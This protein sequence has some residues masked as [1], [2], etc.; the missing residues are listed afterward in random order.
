MSEYKVFKPTKE[1]LD[2]LNKKLIYRDGRELDKDIHKQKMY[3]MYLFH[4][5]LTTDR[6]EF[7]KFYNEFYFELGYYARLIFNREERWLKCMVTE[8]LEEN[9]PSYGVDIVINGYMVP[10]FSE[11]DECNNLFGRMFETFLLQNL[12]GP[13][14][15]EKQHEE[16]YERYNLFSQDIEWFDEEL[17]KISHAVLVKEYEKYLDRDEDVDYEDECQNNDIV[18][19]DGQP[20]Q[21]FLTEKQKEILEND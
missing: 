21:I 7:N 8:Y 1:M 2:E 20:I 18:E 4:R 19:V 9:Q 14:D 10:D 3:I 5:T 17:T 6:T 15:Y 11:A 12:R 13:L 16:W